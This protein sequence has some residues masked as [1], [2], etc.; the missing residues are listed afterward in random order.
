MTTFVEIQWDGTENS[1]TCTSL[2]KILGNIKSFQL[3]TVFFCGFERRVIS[4]FCAWTYMCKQRRKLKNKNQNGDGGRKGSAWQKW[5]N[6]SQ[7]IMYSVEKH[8]YFRGVC[9]KYTG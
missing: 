4:S 7:I 5:P 6:V 8:A 3:V 1:V 2:P 9:M